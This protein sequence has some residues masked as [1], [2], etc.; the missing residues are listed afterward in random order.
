MGL[1]TVER[2]KLH[3]FSF[4]LFLLL[5]VLSRDLVL[6]VTYCM[7]YVDSRLIVNAC[8]GARPSL[9]KSLPTRIFILLGGAISENKQNKKR[10][11]RKS[12]EGLNNVLSFDIL[13]IYAMCLQRV[14]CVVL[15][16]FFCLFLRLGSRFSLSLSLG[17]FIYNF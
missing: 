13:M 16:A 1:M 14:C 7:I 11:S 17:N 2:T 9:L 15:S 4:A 8:K 12:G 5:P 3:L 10:D 6:D